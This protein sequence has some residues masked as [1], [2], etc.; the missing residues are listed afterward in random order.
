M[1]PRLADLQPSAIRAINARK[2]PGDIDLGLGEPTLQPAL[3]PF[4]AALEWVREHGCP[5]S[6]NAGFPEL[7][8]AIAGRYGAPEA[9][10]CVTVGSEEALFLAIKT[11]VDPQRDEVLIPEPCYPA[12][13]KLCALEGIR[14]RTVPMAD[15]GFAPRADVVLDDVRPGT[16][17]I[18]LASPANPTGRIWPEAELRRLA[19]GLLQR[20]GEPVWVL[21]DEVYRE[22]WYTPEAPASMATLY[23][24]TVTTGSLS[25]CCAMTGLRLGWLVGPPVVIGK[26]ITVHGLINTAAGTFGQRVALEMFAAPAL[27][28]T[29]R[30][31]YVARREVLLAAVREHGLEAVPPDGAF[32]A[33]VRVRGRD[34]ADRLLEEHRVV[35]VPGYAFGEAARDWLRISWVAPEDQLREGIKRI[36]LFAA[37]CAQ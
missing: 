29:H 14:V 35:S 32:Y 20:L 22:L 24:Y 18:I 33:M 16:R 31:L 26:A 6:P 5:Y 15:D 2:R 12:Y 4:Q 17:L 7:R 11:L 1:N 8:A 9:D 25:K 27:L 30:P 28:C 19:A 36:A 3:E 37:R 34:A 13:P 21:A 23:P 10:A